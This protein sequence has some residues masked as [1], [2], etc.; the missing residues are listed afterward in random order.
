MA[1]TKYLYQN[2]NYIYYQIFYSFIHKPHIC[3]FFFMEEL[4][5]KIYLF[6]VST[7][8]VFIITYLYKISFLREQPENDEKNIKE[9]PL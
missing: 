5:Q 2:E 7:W 1:L 6:E 3:I 4:A 9:L 8:E